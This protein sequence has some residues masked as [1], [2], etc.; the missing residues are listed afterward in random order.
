MEWSPSKSVIT[1]L[2]NLLDRMEVTEQSQSK[3]K[4][5]QDVELKLLEAKLEHQLLLNEH[6]KILNLQLEQKLRF[7]NRDSV[8][9]D[10]RCDVGRS[11]GPT[12]RVN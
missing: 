6:Q 2:S 10:E 3:P 12:H 7:C 1:Q 11:G 8:I 4:E 9:R 5:F